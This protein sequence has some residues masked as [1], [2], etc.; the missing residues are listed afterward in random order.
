LKFTEKRIK[1]KE[2]FTERTSGSFKSFAIG[3]LAGFGKGTE[4]GGRIPAR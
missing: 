2:L 4:K 1:E 3:S